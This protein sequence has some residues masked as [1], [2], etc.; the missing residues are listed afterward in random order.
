MVGFQKLIK[1]CFPKPFLRTIVPR[2]IPFPYHYNTKEREENSYYFKFKADAELICRVFE[3]RPGI[4]FKKAG[5]EIRVIKLKRDAAHEGKE[6]EIYMVVDVDENG[7][8]TQQFFWKDTN[9]EVE[10]IENLSR[11]RNMTSGI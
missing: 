10:V 11:D 2:D 4:D 9:E 3:N 1:T 6:C 5:D 8:M 7:L